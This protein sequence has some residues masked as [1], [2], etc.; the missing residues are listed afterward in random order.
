M[1]ALSILCLVII[2]IADLTRSA[3][4]TLAHARTISSS[5]SG[6]KISR[7]FTILQAISKYEPFFFFLRCT[8]INRCP[9]I[10]G[11][12]TYVF[13]CLYPSGI[14][15]SVITPILEAGHI[16]QNLDRRKRRYFCPFLVFFIDFHH[17]FFGD[18]LNWNLWYL[19][20]ALDRNW[21][22]WVFIYRCSA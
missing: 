18:F 4:N 21:G 9:D 8:L 2:S 6:Q 20:S 16:F 14:L 22:T 13:G 15:R 19:Q 12:M 7:R 10:E 17:D 3:E 5:K 11:S 1:N